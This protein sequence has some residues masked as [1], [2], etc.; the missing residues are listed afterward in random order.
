MASQAAQAEQQEII[1]TRD[2]KIQEINGYVDLTDEAKDRRVAAVR[3]WAASE[4]HAIQEQDQQKIEKEFRTSRDAVFNVPVSVTYSD[5]EVAQTWQAFRSAFSEVSSVTKIR[6][7]EEIPGAVETLEGIL[8]NA[9][10]FGDKHLEHAVF[11]RAT[12]LATVPIIGRSAEALV[13]RYLSTRPTKAKAW[14][15]YT[16]AAQEINRSRGFE[17]LVSSAYTERVL[18]S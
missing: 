5:A 8:A 4:V 17:S 10:R 6:D 11:V 13:E 15:R 18:N 9:E 14:E 2:A 1:Q 12:D 7:K 3:Q 16:K